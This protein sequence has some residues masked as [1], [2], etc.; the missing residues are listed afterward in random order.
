MRLVVNGRNMDVDTGST[1]AA[2]VAGFN[3]QPK[4]VAV[5][6]NH[7]LVPRRNFDATQLKEGDQVEIVTLVGGG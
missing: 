4:H 6:V 7:E 3:F 1:V 2:L 5:E